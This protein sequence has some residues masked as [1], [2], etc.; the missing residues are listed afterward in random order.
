M[1]SPH[2]HQYCV[3]RKLI[4]LPQRMVVSHEYENLAEFILHELLDPNCFSCI[5]A[6]FFVDN[7]DFDCLKGVAGIS[8]CERFPAECVWDA[9]MEFTDHMKQAPFNTLVRSIALNSST[10]GGRVLEERAQDLAKTIDLQNHE[11]SVF[12]LKHGNQGL[13]LFEVQDMPE[14]VR[15]CIAAGTALL[16][17]CPIF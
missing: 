5:K 4:Q 16:A 6:A 7:P 13:L 11:V 9:H 17:L 8:T 15:E 10:K 12:P 14:P 3:L 1:K 2:E